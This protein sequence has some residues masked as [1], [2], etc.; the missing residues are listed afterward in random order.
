MDEE[1]DDVLWL[2]GDE[3]EYGISLAQL[4]PVTPENDPYDDHV[5]AED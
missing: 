4:I 2:D 3:E 5:S 1:E